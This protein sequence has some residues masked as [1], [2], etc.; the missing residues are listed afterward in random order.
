MLT[1]E[2]AEKRVMREETI[3]LGIVFW[4]LVVTMRKKLILKSF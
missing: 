2:I 1:N 3:F 4:N